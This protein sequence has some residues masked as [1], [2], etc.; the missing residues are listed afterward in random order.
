MPSFS[1]LHFIHFNVTSELFK[2]FE[3]NAQ[4]RL[5]SG[6]FQKLGCL[7][8]LAKV[9]IT[10]VAPGRYDKYDVPRLSLFASRQDN[11]NRQLSHSIGFIFNLKSQIVDVIHKFSFGEW[12]YAVEYRQTQKKRTISSQYGECRKRLAGIPP[13]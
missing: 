2:T 12:K 5:D 9:I 3:M 8:I 6:L 13:P 10:A 4:C 11:I 7:K 1:V